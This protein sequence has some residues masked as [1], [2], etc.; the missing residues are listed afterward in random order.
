MILDLR[1]YKFDEGC[2]GLVVFVESEAK[3][4]KVFMKNHTLEQAENVFDS[5]VDAYN[6]VQNCEEAKILTPDFYGTVNVTQIIDS[7]GVD[8]SHKYYR[9]LAYV[10]SYE[11][12]AFQKLAITLT[13]EAS[14]IERIFK[15]IGVNYT[16]D[17]SVILSENQIITKVI[18]FAVE[19][20]EVWA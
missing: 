19:E 2:Y 14:R 15:S 16:R 3:A 20:F 8:I 11:S 13:S 6:K 18:D 12:G 10:M 4:V 1:K 7:N 9:D 17:A 5:E